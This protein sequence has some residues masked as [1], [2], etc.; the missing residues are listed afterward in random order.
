M[1][2]PAVQN[3]TSHVS[4]KNDLSE[5]QLLVLNMVRRGGKALGSLVW[6]VNCEV[7]VKLDGTRPM[8]G[9]CKLWENSFGLNVFKLD[10]MFTLN[11][12]ASLSTIKTQYHN[13]TDYCLYRTFL[14]IYIL[15]RM[16]RCMIDSIRMMWWRYDMLRTNSGCTLFQHLLVSDSVFQSMKISEQQYGKI[17]F[18]FFIHYLVDLSTRF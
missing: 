6:H 17:I 11:C 16:M 4:D 18:I 5:E 14:Y 12:P 15:Y 7:H 1:S 9:L 2:V 3:Y 10:L 8:N 13:L